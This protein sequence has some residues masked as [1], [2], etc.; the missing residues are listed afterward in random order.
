MSVFV[1]FCLFFY[2][3]SFPGEFHGELF[4]HGPGTASELGN[5]P[6]RYEE[7]KFLIY[8]KKKSQFLAGS[9]LLLHHP[10]HSSLQILLVCLSLG[11]PFF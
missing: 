6:P 7:D 8:K 11:S 5:N 1:L 10:T 9:F 3:F 4:S 2:H